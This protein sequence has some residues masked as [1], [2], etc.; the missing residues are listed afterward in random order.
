MIE[1]Q[2]LGDG[3]DPET[4]ARL[5]EAVRADP[6]LKAAYDRY[7]NLEVGLADGNLSGMRGRIL[8]SVQAEAAPREA[9]AE[10]P[11]DLAQARARRRRWIGAGVASGL[12]A[13]AAVGL[14]TLTPGGPRQ[15]V[16][17]SYTLEV[18]AGAQALRGDE[19]KTR[20]F[21]PG[22]RM[23]IVLRPEAPSSEGLEARA[24]LVSARGTF[25]AQGA[26]QSAGGAFKLSGPA[27]DLFEAPPG[28][29]TLIAVVARAE[30]MPE[31]LQ[32]SG[33]AD[34]R[35]TLRVQVE[36]TEHPQ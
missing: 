10:P 13:A 5:F 36:L 17:P 21:G 3:L 22:T 34:G 28:V 31:D 18:S 1:Q 14:L 24:A 9:T 32:E 25:V 33:P 35:V 30:A 15:G 27:K 19:A 16:M 4:R 2:F 11:I 6:E 23:S 8:S 20:R 12:V 26:W 7:A 29:Y